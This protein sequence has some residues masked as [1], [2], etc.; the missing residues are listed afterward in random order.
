MKSSQYFVDLAMIGKLV[1]I[2]NVGISSGETTLNV[3]KELLLKGKSSSK[4]SKEKTKIRRRNFTRW[5]T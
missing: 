2:E 5:N 1:V 3:T 4:Y